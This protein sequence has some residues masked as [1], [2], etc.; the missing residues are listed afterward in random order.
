GKLRGPLG[1]VTSGIT[2]SRELMSRIVPMAEA[3]YI[4]ADNYLIL[5]AASLA[6]GIYLREAL[7]TQR[8]H[9]A[10][11]YTMRPDRLPI[12]ARI[13]LLIAASLRWRYP[14][15]WRLANHVFS[16]GLAKYHCVGTDDVCRETISRYLQD[17][18]PTEWPD[19]FLRA[20]Y[21]RVR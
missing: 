20:V 3:I 2:M 12:E 10:N 16:Q 13:H 1:P 11:R 17:T 19:L 15:L 7:A 8:I 6:P 18:S 4:T 5:A 9:D 14:E 21:H